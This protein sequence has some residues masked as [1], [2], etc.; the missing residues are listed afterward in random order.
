MPPTLNG[1]RI[2]GNCLNARDGTL[3]AVGRVV[4][5]GAALDRY[6]RR[7]NPNPLTLAAVG[8]APTEAAPGRY[9]RRYK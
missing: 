2:G 7:A 4:P 3:A 5:T 1:T 9:L 8:P 6:L